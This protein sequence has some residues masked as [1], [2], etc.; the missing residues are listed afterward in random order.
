MK[1]LPRF[2]TALFLTS[3]YLVITMSPLAPIAMR[4]P[5]IAHAVTGECIGNC[6]VCGCSPEMRANHICCCWK[7]KQQQ[8]HQHQY[9]ADC[10]KN[11][12]HH[13][14]TI[15]TCNCPCGSNK[16]PGLMGAQNFEQLP[17]RYTE[18]E[19]AL[20]E[21]S[22]SSFLRYC[23]TDRHGDPPDPPPKLAV[24]PKISITHA[25]LIFDAEL[26]VLQAHLHLGGTSAR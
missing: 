2:I 4:S 10:C 19:I 25:A 13:K 17:Y 16:L 22:L 12:K 18:G 6:D 11:K 7:K 9:V 3:I 5:L 15:S 14:M 23:M 21:D 20:H 24:F 1:S 26:V 8:A